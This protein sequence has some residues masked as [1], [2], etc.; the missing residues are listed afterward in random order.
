MTKSRA[1]SAPVRSRK[2]WLYI[3][4]GT[5]SKDLA[6]LDAYGFETWQANRLTKAGD[7]IIMYRSAPYSDIAYVFVAK[8]DARR[9]RPADRVPW[10]FVVDIA[11]GYRLPRVVTRDELKAVP[12]L[13]RWHFLRHARGA[14]R[15]LDDL[16]EQ[17]VW[18]A[19]RRILEQ[20]APEL[21]RHFGRAWTGRGRRR[22]AFL[23]YSSH[24]RKRVNRMY[25]DLASQGI[26]LWLDS[27]QLEP[28]K[29]WEDSIERAIARSK[30]VIICLS[31]SWLRRRG[32][33][34]RELEIALKYAR[35]KKIRILPIVIERCSVPASVRAYHAVSFPKRNAGTARQNF[36]RYVRRRVLRPN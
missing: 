9:T 26:E 21:P 5:Y 19:L 35:R 17:G 8:S 33:V 2:V 6:R 31:P 27:V 14:A 18:P 16:Q 34:R 24:D 32:Y 25:E 13:S 30:A 7:L 1:K 15:R 29:E 36:L 10:K 4:Y 28:G 22:Y 23:S 12:G 3:A 11:D 20:R